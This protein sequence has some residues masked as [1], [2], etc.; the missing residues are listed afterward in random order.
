MPTATCRTCWAIPI[1]DHAFR[2][3]ASTF[4]AEHMHPE[5]RAAWLGSRSA[6]NTQ[7]GWR[8]ARATSDREGRRWR[9]ALD[10]LAQPGLS[11]RRDAGGQRHAILG[12]MDDITVTRQAQEDLAASQRLLN[13]V[14][15]TVPNVLYVLDFT[16]QSVTAAWSTATVRCRPLLGYSPT[17]IAED[18][19]AC[20][21]C[22]DTCTPTTGTRSYGDRGQRL[23]GC[24][25]RRDPGDRIPPARCRRQ[26]ALDARTRPGL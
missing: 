14:A 16:D 18:G 12:I 25:G 6:I 22:R 7:I 8:G 9:L 21:S 17:V 1:S 24:P 20:V 11:A 23:L 2:A 19:L 5:D 4:L 10:P 15:Q 13:R 3:M 26:L